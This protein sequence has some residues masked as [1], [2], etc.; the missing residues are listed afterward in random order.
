MAK[1]NGPNFS[2]I[3]LNAGHVG[4]ASGSSPVLTDL[5]PVSPAK[6]AFL[7]ALPVRSSTAHEDQSVWNRSNS[8][9]LE[10]CC[11]G[12]QVILN[13]TSKVVGAEDEDG[14]AGMERDTVRLSHQSRVWMCVAGIPM[15]ER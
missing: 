9:R 11:A 10:E 12:V 2:P 5:Y 6:Y 1:S 14:V 7:P 3:S 13:C 4:T 8:V 15:E